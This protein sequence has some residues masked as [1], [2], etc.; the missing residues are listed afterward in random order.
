MQHEQSRSAA[1]QIA[2]GLGWFSIGLGLAELA[3]PSSVA[4]LIGIDDND[5]SRSTLRFYGLRELGAG[6]AILAQPSN[7][8]WL[9]SRVAG[10]A[11]DL[12]SMG[13]ATKTDPGK[14]T[15]ATAAVLGVTALDVYCAT[16]L[17]AQSTS[18][19]EPV[20]TVNTVRVNKPVEAVYHFWRNFENLPRFMKHLERVEVIDDRRSHWVARAP[21]GRTAEWDAE[22]VADQ[23]G[24]LIAW[25]S[26]PGSDI[27]NSGQVRF[28]RAT[29][30]RGTIVR[31]ELQYTPPGGS[32]GALAAKLTGEE[33][34]Q[35]IYEDL[36]RFKQIVETGEV[37][38]SDASIHTR[39]HSAQ[40]T[41]KVY[42]DLAV[43]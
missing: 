21:L 28:E 33:P 7:P 42:E 39:M 20:S 10:D 2:V 27:D 30:G 14:T 12:A 6:I 18:E 17:S 23:P 41:E 22:I 15:I 37:I 26:L 25:R 8:K 19:T 4:R 24:S 16:Q 40:P 36:R 31:V 13:A 3:S 38:H 35:Q 5:T 1:E 11:V 29:G 9:W 43:R 32:V 34:A